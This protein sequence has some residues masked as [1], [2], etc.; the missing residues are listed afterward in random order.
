MPTYSIF[1][2]F[3]YL[4]SDCL[5]QNESKIQ[6]FPI[7]LKFDQVKYYLIAFPKF[8]TRFIP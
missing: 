2:V 8:P 1:S 6:E 5:V 4:L 3:S 7:S